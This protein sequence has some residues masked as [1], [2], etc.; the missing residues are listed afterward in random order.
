VQQVMT[1]IELAA[2]HRSWIDVDQVAQ[3]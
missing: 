2:Q 1:A 3:A